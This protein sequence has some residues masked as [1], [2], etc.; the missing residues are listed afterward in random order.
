MVIIFTIFSFIAL[1]AGCMGICAVFQYSRSLMSSFWI[2]ML[3]C[4]LGFATAAAI[5]LAV[6]LYFQSGGCLGS[7]YAATMYI[8]NQ[9]TLAALRLCKAS[10]VNC[11]CYL[12]PNG[13]SYTSLNSI[14]GLS[15]INNN[16]SLPIN[17][18]RCANWTVGV[19]DTTLAAF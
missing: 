4:M 15:T 8:N 19:Y 7:S 17:V 5:A 14:A 18:F 16:Y 6:P 11:T 2:C 1:F 10:P 9:T 12:N 3:V 13:T